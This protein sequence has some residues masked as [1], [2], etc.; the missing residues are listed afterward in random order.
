MKHLSFV[1]S[2]VL[3]AVATLSGVVLAQEQRG[4]IEGTV[5]DSSGAVLPGVTVEA[6]SPALVGVQ[7][8]VSDANGTYRFPALAPGRYELTATLQG[9][10]AARLADVSLELGKLLKVDLTLAPA[11]VAETVQ[12]TGESP[13]IDVKQNAAGANIQAE[14]IERI[15]RARNT[16]LLPFARQTQRTCKELLKKSFGLVLTTAAIPVIVAIVAIIG[17]VAIVAPVI[18]PPAAIAIAQSTTTPVIVVAVPI[19]SFETIAEAVA[20]ITAMAEV[21]AIPDVGIFIN[22]TAFVI[23]TIST[24][25][26]PA[27]FAL[28]KFKPIAPSDFAD[29]I[30]VVSTLG[31]HAE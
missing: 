28:A 25:D 15:P 26:V 19:A 5:R 6:R 20:V 2:C 31:Q 10:S 16:P 14:T 11:G 3:V 13:L 23:E 9:F 29:V 27:T 17:I 21:V 7:S 8:T 1:L 24:L 4:S 22:P 18:T 12:V 30:L